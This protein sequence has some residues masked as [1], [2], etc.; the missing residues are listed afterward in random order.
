MSWPDT[1]PVD[2]ES[3]KYYDETNETWVD[4]L[5]LQDIG[6]ASVK[7]FLICISGNG[8]VYYGEL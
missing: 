6:G 2:Y 8:S 3:D 7:E 1:R 5:D 4:Q